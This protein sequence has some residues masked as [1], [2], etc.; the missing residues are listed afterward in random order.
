[1]FADDCKFLENN[2]TSNE[3]ADMNSVSKWL[4]ENKLT[5]NKTK[6]VR[7][8]FNRVQYNSDGDPIYAK[9]LGY[10]HYLSSFT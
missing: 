10:Y 8:Q 3:M 5:L 7:V 1:M 2:S 9:Y 4:E 6:T